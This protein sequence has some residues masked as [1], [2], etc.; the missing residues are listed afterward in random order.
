MRCK[1]NALIPQASLS[2]AKITIWMVAVRPQA[3]VQA[4]EPIHQKIV[5]AQDS[6]F[7]KTAAHNAECQTLDKQIEHWDAMARPP[8]GAQMQDWFKE[9]R[10]QTRDRQFRIRCR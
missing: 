8:H 5:V 10:Q 9:Q 2:R 7:N 6:Q 4:E 1:R 3:A